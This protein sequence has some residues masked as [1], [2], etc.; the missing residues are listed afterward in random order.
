[1]VLQKNADKTLNRVVLPKSFIDANG[2]AFQ[3]EVHKD[4]IILIPIKKE[5]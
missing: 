1:M 2:R 5:G 3:M 4:K